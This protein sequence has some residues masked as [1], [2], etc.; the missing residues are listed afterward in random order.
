V[1]IDLMQPE[2]WACSKIS[3]T[4]MYWWYL[5]FIFEGFLVKKI[6]FQNIH[7]TKYQLA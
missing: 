3:K 1:T 6:V 2:L 7:I 4:H 5:S